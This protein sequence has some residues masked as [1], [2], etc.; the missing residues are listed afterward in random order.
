[1]RI[2]TGFGA[3]SCADAFRGCIGCTHLVELFGP[4]ATTAIQTVQPLRR[5]FSGTDAEARPV[6]ID[7]CHA[8]AAEGEVVA[9][10]WPRFHQ[11]PY[12]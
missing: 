11:R 10:Y 1:M 9:R 8:L 7:T 6:Q 12:E 3:E 5:E 4:L 2:G